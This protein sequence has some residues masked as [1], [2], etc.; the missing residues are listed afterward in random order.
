MGK[1]PHPLDVKYDLLQCTLS[2]VDKKSQESKVVISST[3]SFVDLY[4]FSLCF[5]LYF[6]KLKVLLYRHIAVML[7]LETVSCLK[8][9]LRHILDVLVLVLWIGVS[10]LVLTSL[11]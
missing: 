5:K 9:V 1:E 7:S 2:L 4:S 11:S 3:L 6:S 8:T 10:A